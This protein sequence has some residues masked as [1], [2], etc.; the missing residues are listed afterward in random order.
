MVSSATSWIN[1]G[2]PFTT[3]YRA[4]HLSA[5]DIGDSARTAHHSHLH[6]HPSLAGSTASSSRGL[7]CGVGQMPK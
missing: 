5:L 3:T 7:A 6:Q 1:S 2:H 4:L